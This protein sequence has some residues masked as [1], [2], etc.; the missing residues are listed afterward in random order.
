MAASGPYSKAFRG[1][2]C[3]QKVGGRPGI[4]AP[5]LRRPGRR[6]VPC[7]GGPLPWLCRT[8]G[9]WATVG[10]DSDNGGDTGEPPPDDELL[11]LGGAV[12]DGERAGIAEVAFDRVVLHE[13]EGPVELD[14][15]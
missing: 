10:R 2:R 13:P 4:W 9:S 15:L 12:G 14:G 6:E 3:I 11:D 5:A 1:Y 7:P 8:Y